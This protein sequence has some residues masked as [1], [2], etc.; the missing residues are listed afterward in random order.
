MTAPVALLDASA[1][2]AWLFQERGHETVSKLAGKCVI[3]SANMTEVLYRTAQEGYERPLADLYDDL[4]NGGFA[5]VE[6]APEDAVL[7]AQ[8]IASSRSKGGHLSLG[9][10]LCIATASRLGLPIVGGDQ[11][12]EPLD[13]PAKVIPFR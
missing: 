8:L 6:N 11:E 5:V 2:L 12:W 9:D 4:V 13:L 3:A 10:G 1:L 7:A